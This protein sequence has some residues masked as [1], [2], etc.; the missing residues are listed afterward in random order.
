[1]PSSKFC[2][3]QKLRELPKD[4]WIFSLNASTITTRF[5]Q[6][7]AHWQISRSSVFDTQSSSEEQKRGRI[8]KF[9]MFLT[10]RN[11][12]FQVSTPSPSVSRT[13]LQ[14]T[15]SKVEG[16]PESSKTLKRHKKQNSFVNITIQ[17]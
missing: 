6:C 16:C 15:S 7:F 10:T 9:I 1:M 13:M 2:K 14:H 5:L 4:G 8:L 12:I 11:D 17:T 3:C